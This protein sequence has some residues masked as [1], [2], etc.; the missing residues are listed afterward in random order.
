MLTQFVLGTITW[1]NNIQHSKWF[2]LIKTFEKFS[3]YVESKPNVYIQAGIY[4]TINKEGRQ[5]IQ[6]KMSSL[7]WHNEKKYTLDAIRDFVT[8]W[9]WSLEQI[10]PHHQ[11]PKFF[12]YWVSRQ[13]LKQFPFP[14]IKFHGC[15]NKQT[16]V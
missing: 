9:L 7:V 11:T 4:F 13:T 10:I 5:E 3:H 8:S 6:K 15:S 1:V 12:L 16:C 2:C 14:D